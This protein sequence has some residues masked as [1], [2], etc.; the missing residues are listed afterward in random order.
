ME[1]N[2]YE[3]LSNEQLIEKRDSYKKISKVL[4]ALGALTLIGFFFM[5]GYAIGKDA[6]TGGKGE[7]YNKPFIVLLIAFISGTFYM[8]SEVKSIEKEIQRR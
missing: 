2:T 4:L 5:I 6:A 7:F 3:S 8:E 1:K